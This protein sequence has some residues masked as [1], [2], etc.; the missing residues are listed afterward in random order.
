MILPNE[1]RE[2]DQSD[3][4]EDEELFKC[5]APASRYM[6][7]AAESTIQQDPQH[8]NTSTIND[9]SHEWLIEQGAQGRTVVGFRPATTGL[10]TNSTGGK[11]PLNQAPKAINGSSISSR[12][13]A[14][15]YWAFVDNEAG[16][17]S[18]DLLT[19]YSGCCHSH[20][21]A[22]K[23]VQFENTD[24][25]ENLKVWIWPHHDCTKGNSRSLNVPPGTLIKCQDR[26]TYPW[27]G[28]FSLAIS[29]EERAGVT[30]CSNLKAISSKV[31]QVSLVS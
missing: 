24:D 3:N 13:T 15:V 26:T 9:T 25:H 20:A 18:I 30:L 16:C 29:A 21:S 31:S 19:S 2:I 12:G 10:R 17:Q 5:L 22:F 23:S 4:G 8:A 1:R 11:S 7:V 6:N 28:R 27:L 14:L